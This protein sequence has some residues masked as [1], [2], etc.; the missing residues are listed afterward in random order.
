MLEFRLSSV[1][2]KCLKKSLF[3]FWNLRVSSTYL[4]KSLLYN[5]L[6]NMECDYVILVF[7]AGGY[8]QRGMVA[9]MV[10]STQV[11]AEFDLCYLESV[12]E[13]VLLKVN[14]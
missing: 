11:R 4:S 14:S 1:A 7:R 8:D 6:P 2:I 9:T 10:Y 12:S 5:F 3:H 13:R